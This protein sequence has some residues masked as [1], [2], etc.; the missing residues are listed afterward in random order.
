[1]LLS[2]VMYRHQ[3]T[4]LQW[5]GTA[6][7]FVGLAIEAREKRKEGLVKRVLQQKTEG[8]PREDKK[9]GVKDA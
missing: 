4:T 8:R 9:A 3:L 7:V 6:L 5:S 2:V 1:M